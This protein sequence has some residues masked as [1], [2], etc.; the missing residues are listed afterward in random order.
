MSDSFT[1]SSFAVSDDRLSVALSYELD[2]NAATHTLTEVFSFET[3]LPDVYETNQLLRALHLACGVS[4]Y[5]IFMPA[6]ISHPYLMDEAEATF[7]NDVYRGGLGE[8]LYVNKL[9]PA[10]LAK[11]SAQDGSR[12][13]A[14]EPLELQPAALLGIGGGKDSIVA[15]ET[16]KKIGV[17]LQG[18]V[19]A[20]GEALG[21]AG[22][23]AKV[24][25]TPLHV[26]GRKLDAHLL[27]LQ[28]QPGAYK[29]HIPI[30][31]VFG[32]VGGLLAVTHGSAYVVVANEDSASTPQTMWAGE[33]VN[34][35][36][37][38]SFAFEGQLQA[39]LH[40]HISEQLTYFSAIRPLGSVGVARA[41]VQFPQY[42]EVFT[43]D[44]F[45]FRQ[46]PAKRPNSRWSLESPKSLSSFIL[47]S[48]LLSEADMVKIFG[49]NFFEKI[50]LKDLFLSLIGIA[51]E[52]PLDCV[53]TPPE[54]AA[55]LAVTIRQGKWQGSALLDLPEML[56]LEAG[57]LADFKTLSDH[58]HF[59]PALLKKLTETLKELA[60]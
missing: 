2:H 21:Q 10:G 47:L 40:E 29:G 15:G 11:F 37:S 7:W 60:A 51:G 53:G 44:N 13:E 48:P 14:T 16:L 5:K 1:Y 54:L 30:S 28:E 19:M 22:A 4:Y 6:T 42:F 41:F 32:L 39:Y 20:T 17:P 23:V 50:E 12:F 9:D 8:F 35:Q 26:V 38:K 56:D 57:S 46:D 55:S 34:H 27:E 18:F 25:G 52:T 3:A 43:S 24:M 59:P 49:I 36:W 33:P 31:L 45:V 58:Q